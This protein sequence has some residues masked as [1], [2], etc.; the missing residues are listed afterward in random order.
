M[1]CANKFQLVFLFVLIM[2]E[3]S[4]QVKID[5]VTAESIVNRSIDNC[6]GEILL[7]SLTSIDFISKIATPEGDTLSFAVKRSGFDKYYIS[8]LGVN[9]ESATTIYN[10]G[11]AVIIKNESVQ[12]IIDPVKLEELLLQC[13]ISIDYGYKKL[14]YK[15]KRLADHKFNHYDCYVVQATASSG[16]E[17]LNF[18]DKETG[19]LIMIVYPSGNK[20]IF[21]D[22]YKT[23]G[24]TIPS[25]I[26]S[27]DGDKK[28]MQDF[29]Q[30]VNCQSKLDTNWFVIPNEGAYK[31]P[32][33]FKTGIFKYVDS[34]Q[35]V[36]IV[37][38]IDTDIEEDDH[39]KL[40]FKIKWDNSSE[41]SLYGVKD[42]SYY[43]T[44]ITAWKGNRY[45]CQSLSSKNIGGTC[46]IEKVN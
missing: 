21:I 3:A 46:I 7:D 13:F 27:T 40:E 42:G 45:Y 2:S 1:N 31:I 18:Y 8:T 25:I 19:N 28:P 22:F 16:R 17:W 43:K 4:A 14:G 23:S 30:K 38:T 33:I 26:L 41:Y 15:F 12:K 10:H 32:S 24:I 39:S 6:G 34:D 35:G 5:S 44:R 20:A 9:Y 37:R 29:L 11:R 36:K